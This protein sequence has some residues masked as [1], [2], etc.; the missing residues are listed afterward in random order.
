MDLGSVS[1]KLFQKFLKFYTPAT[2]LSYFD[3]NKK[4]VL[5]V[6][7]SSF[8][9]FIPSVSLNKPQQKYIQIEKE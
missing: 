1:R 3:P 2:V 7:E 5:S 6:D 8:E 9:R 4:T